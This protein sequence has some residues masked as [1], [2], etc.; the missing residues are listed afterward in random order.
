M[1]CSGGGGLISAGPSQRDVV[2]RPWDCQ[3]EV[4]CLAHDVAEM[5]IDFEMGFP[6]PS[7]G[8]GAR[9]STAAFKFD[10]HR[11]AAKAVDV[12]GLHSEMWK[13][14]KTLPRLYGIQAAC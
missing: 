9:R 11:F 13:Y 3:R 8:R 14:I 6:S 5:G 12:K 4:T 7:S 2:S 10:H 1:S